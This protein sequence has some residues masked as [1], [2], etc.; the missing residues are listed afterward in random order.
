MPTQMQPSRTLPAALQRARR[1]MDRANER[2]VAALQARA[3]LA[4]EI[5]G[6]KRT[7]GLRGADPRREREMLERL[8]RDA[9]AGFGRPALARILR[10]IFAHSRALVERE[11]KATRKVR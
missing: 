5:G 1:R 6:L 3:R 9:P 11:T 7:L 2:L 8:L 4:R 10:E